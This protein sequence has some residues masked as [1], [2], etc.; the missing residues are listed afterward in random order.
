VVKLMEE[1]E[2]AVEKKVSRLVK[3]G[4]VKEAIMVPWR[5]DTA[6]RPPN[7]GVTAEVEAA[8]GAVLDAEDPA[9]GFRKLVT[10]QSIGAETGGGSWV[11][12]G[13]VRHQAHIQEGAGA[14]VGEAEADA[15]G[16]V[17]QEEEWEQQ[18]GWSKAARRKRHVLED[19][20]ED[21]PDVGVEAEQAGV[22]GK[23]QT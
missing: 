20:Q 5:L 18:A 9:E 17:E 8:L 3:Q 15:P 12:A 2:A 7:V 22:P 6:G 13:V 16:L 23:A 10:R 14:E 4:P 19:G 1:M 21:A 11:G